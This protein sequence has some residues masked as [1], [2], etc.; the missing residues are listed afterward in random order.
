[1][2]MDNWKSTV[3]RHERG[4]SRRT[5]CA[6]LAAL[7]ALPFLS[8]QAHAGTYDD[9]PLFQTERHQFTLVRPSVELPAVSLTDLRGRSAR[10]T[11][12]PGNVLLINFWATWCAACRTD[13]PLLERFHEAVR[14]PVNVAAVSSDKADR[15][16]VRVYLEKL[17]I[18]HLPV[19]LDPE[20]R[21]ASDSSDSLAPLQLN[22]MPITYLVTPQGRIAGYI[23]G[24][25]DWLSDDAQRLL[26]HYTAA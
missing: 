22:G 26:A 8:R 1:M 19:Y 14:G 10:I 2:F 11:A 15:E 18:R 23:S 4:P 6:S 17:S 7:A 12:V 16:K 21:L 13:L 9:P 25:V 3:A 20:A 24:P 5:V